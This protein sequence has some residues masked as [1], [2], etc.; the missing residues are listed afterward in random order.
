MYFIGIDQSLAN[1]GV[2]ILQYGQF[3]STHYLGSIKSKPL[4]SSGATR[5]T[6]DLLKLVRID[7][8]ID[9]II[10]MVGKLN[11]SKP[12]FIAIESPSF[13]TQNVE[14]SILY[15]KLADRLWDWLSRCCPVDDS[16]VDQLLIV[17]PNEL[18]RFV[19][20]KG[21]A[22]KELMVSATGIKDH[23]QADAFG[24]ASLSMF[25]KTG[26]VHPGL[27]AK[28]DPK[29]AKKLMEA[30]EGVLSNL[31]VPYVKKKR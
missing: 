18:K 28:K 25:I 30:R 24:L 23:N 13:S 3:V 22:D 31:T 6:L 29:E 11:P 4:K 15:G 5:S 21:N 7:N 9:E 27:L 19:T 1:T 14:L 20:G 10:E 2:C 16:G 12:P 26:F 8:I 17:L